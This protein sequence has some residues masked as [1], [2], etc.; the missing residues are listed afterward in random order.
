[1]LSILKLFDELFGYLAIITMLLP[2]F[3]AIQARKHKAIF[4][5][6][7]KLF[8][9]YVYF[10]L[11]LQCISLTLSYGFGLHNILLFR[12]YLP[13][14]TAFFSYF[15][16]KWS[17]RGNIIF[18]LIIITLISIMGDY[19]YGDPNYSPDIMIWSDAIILLFLSFL[20]S[21]KIDK[22]KNKLPC[23]HNFI[24]IGIY[25]YSIVTLLGLSPS[26]TDVRVFGFLLQAFAVIISN[27]YFARSFRCLYP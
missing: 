27:Y 1:M 3:A 18:L 11:I 8:E 6:D 25:L 12:I 17:R 9:I 15:L 13:I 21:Y 7:L 5:H 26:H 4:S 20:L 2:I 22:K 14:H 10:T 16:I 19:F 23:E 24:H